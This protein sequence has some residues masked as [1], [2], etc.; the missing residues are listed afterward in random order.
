MLSERDSALAAAIGRYDGETHDRLLE[1]AVDVLVREGFPV[2][3]FFL[4][5]SYNDDTEALC[6]ADSEV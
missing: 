5:A 2:S 3:A 4:R 6:Y 1:A